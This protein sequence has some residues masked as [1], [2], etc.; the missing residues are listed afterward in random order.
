M[1]GYLIFIIEQLEEEKKILFG[2]SLFQNKSQRIP[3]DKIPGNEFEIL[4]NHKHEK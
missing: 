4:K 1:Q 2:E 3:I